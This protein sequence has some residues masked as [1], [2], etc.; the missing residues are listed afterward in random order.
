MT[1]TNIS[2]KLV[3]YEV[4]QYVTNQATRIIVKA[5][6]D[7]AI[8]SNMVDEPVALINQASLVETELQKDVNSNVKAHNE[9][10]EVLID[11]ESYK[12]TIASDRSWV[13]S[14]VDLGTLIF[15]TRPTSVLTRR[16]AEWIADGCG[17]LGTGG[18]GSPYPP[19][20]V[21]RQLLREGNII[22]VSL[23]AIRRHSYSVSKFT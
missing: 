16:I 4:K 11:I 7:L 2:S 18:G 23:L 12:P 14:E 17:V 8:E 19:F 3:V 20:L 1:R 21:A 9:G 6:G 22:R 13:L 5:A 15:M 10:D